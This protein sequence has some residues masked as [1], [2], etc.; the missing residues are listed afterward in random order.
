V[1][2]GFDF[3]WQAGEFPSWAPFCLCHQGFLIFVQQLN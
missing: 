3:G 1:L 2:F